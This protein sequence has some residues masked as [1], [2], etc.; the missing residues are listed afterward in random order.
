MDTRPAQ[1]GGHGGRGPIP[2]VYGALSSWLLGEVNKMMTRIKLVASLRFS[3]SKKR[4]KGRGRFSAALRDAWLG[5]G[6][7]ANANA[8]VPDAT[9]Q[10]EGR[11]RPQQQAVADT[12]CIQGINEGMNLDGS[13]TGRG[14]LTTHAAANTMLSLIICS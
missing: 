10:T 6:G 4:G 12:E 2:C 14:S 5:A 7:E 13:L 11:G 3:M 8:V 9:L 1:Q